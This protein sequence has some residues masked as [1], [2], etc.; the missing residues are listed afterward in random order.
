MI[1]IGTFTLLQNAM[2]CDTLFLTTL[3]SLECLRWTRCWLRGASTSSQ[4]ILPSNPSPAKRA[5]VGIWDPDSLWGGRRRSYWLAYAGSVGKNHPP[6]PW[7]RGSC[8]RLTDPALMSVR[9][10]ASLAFV[11]LSSRFTEY[12]RKQFPYFPENTVVSAGV[13]A[14]NTSLSSKYFSLLISSQGTT[15][16]VSIS[17]NANKNSLYVYNSL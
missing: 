8:G 12:F 15:C 13:R 7:S 10:E 16:P 17:D 6:L 11:T 3:V 2:K 14:K 4:V 5:G 1:I 9:A